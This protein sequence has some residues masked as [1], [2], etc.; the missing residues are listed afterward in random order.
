VYFRE[1]LKLNEDRNTVVA[2]TYEQTFNRML[3][4]K[5]IV[6]RGQ[7]TDGSAK[8]FDELIFD[9]NTAYFEENGGYDYAKKFFEEA[10]RCAVNEVGGEQ[11]IISAVLHADEKNKALSEQLGRDVFHYHLHVVYV[12]VVQKEILWSKRT[13]DKSLVGKVKEVIRGGCIM[14]K[15]KMFRGIAKVLVL[16]LVVCLLSSLYVLADTDIATGTEAV[17]DK[18]ANPEGETPSEAGMPTE[19]S[20]KTETKT[21]IVAETAA[22]VEI[23]AAMAIE[24]ATG[25]VGTGGAPWTL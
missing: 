4:E 15:G 8:V 11:Y 23:V 25:T 17:S 19:P 7:K 1:R 2:E 14:R 13:K 5:I 3:D 20:P 24:R 22:E 16:C 21:E 18:D 6:Q 12:P 9:V 10:Y